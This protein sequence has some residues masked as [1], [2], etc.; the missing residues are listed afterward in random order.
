MSI[1]MCREDGEKSNANEATKLSLTTAYNLGSNGK[2]KR[3]HKP[4]IKAIVR[5]CEGRVEDWPQ[6]LASTHNLVTR[7]MQ[8]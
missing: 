1:R 8:S 4:T 5:A 3:G 6:L 2:I 7:F